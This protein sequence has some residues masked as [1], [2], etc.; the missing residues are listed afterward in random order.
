MPTKM[1]KDF[2]CKN[3][4][5][6]S[7][8]NAGNRPGPLEKD[9]VTGKSMVDLYTERKATGIIPSINER[10]DPILSK[11][12]GVVFFQEQCIFI[13]QEMAGYNLGNADIRIRKT[14]CKKMGKKIPEIRNEFVYGKKSLFD[15]DHNVI[16][17]SDEPSPYC[18]GAIARGFTEEEAQ[19]MFDNMENFAKYAFN[20]SHSGCYSVV[21]YK[22]AWISFYHPVEF[23]IANCTINDASEKIRTTLALARKRK[24][25]ILGPDI[26]NSSNG[27]SVENVNGVKGIRYGLKAIQGVGP[28]VL[29]F[30]LE[31]K[32]RLNKVFTSFD[33]FYDKFHNSPEAKQLV[34]ELQNM[35]GKRTANPIKKD[36]EVAMILSG[37]FDYCE[38]NRYALYMHYMVDIRKEKKFDILDPKDYTRSAK[39]ALEEKYLGDFISEHP[40]DPF[41]YADIDSCADNEQV[42]IAGIVTAASL[43]STKTG[44]KYI[45]VSMKTRDGLERNVNMFDENK[46]LSLKQDIKKNQIIT[47]KGRVSKQFNNITASSIKILAA[48][49]QMSNMTALTVDD[50]TKPPEPPKPEKEPQIELPSMESFFGRS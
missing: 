23:A 26:N 48:S 25:P 39:L 27:F 40:L 35:T 21:G 3:L 1:L 30:L 5:D 49:K 13:G 34:A 17:I 22:E 37:C 10:I 47:V 24:I 12:L 9:A 45:A 36:V 8:V 38:P 11:T 41:A 16:G 46:S 33:E 43:K 29:I 28:A 42:E 19:K 20:Q 7:A 18:E 31:L 14:L 32:K 4:L 15:E 6:L 2:D 50:L 44:K